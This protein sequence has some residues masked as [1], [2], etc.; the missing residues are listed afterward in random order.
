[1]LLFFNLYA[2]VQQVKCDIFTAN[3]CYYITI[4]FDYA[5][6]DSRLDAYGGVML[7]RFEFIKVCMGKKW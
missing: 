4:K 6:H 5:K 1:M 7:S 3:F 2:E